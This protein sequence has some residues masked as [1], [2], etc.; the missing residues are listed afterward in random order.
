MIRRPPGSSRTYP[1]FPYTTLFRSRSADSN[2]PASDPTRSFHGSG[3]LVTAG[4]GGSTPFPQKSA[5]K[6]MPVNRV[7]GAPSLKENASDTAVQGRPYLGVIAHRD[8]R[9]LM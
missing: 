8:A 9:L 5:V 6:G 3:N 1:L 7:G 4:R 2:L